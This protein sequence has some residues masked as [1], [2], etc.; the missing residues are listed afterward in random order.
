MKITVAAFV[1]F[2]FT[3]I[4]SAQSSEEGIVAQSPIYP[5]VS[6]LDDNCLMGG[7]Q[8]G[9]RL[10]DAEAAPRLTGNEVYRVYTMSGFVGRCVGSAPVSAPVPCAEN[11]RITRFRRRLKASSRLVAIGTRSLVCQNW[12]QAQCLCQL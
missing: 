5:I 2:L 10:S 4:G 12:C 6:L 7:L 3:Q 11:W 8:E 1:V 9:V